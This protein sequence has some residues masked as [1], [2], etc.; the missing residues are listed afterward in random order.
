[1]FLSYIDNKY[2]YC[3]VALN[4]VE[5]DLGHF[6]LRIGCFR[7]KFSLSVFQLS[8]RVHSSWAVTTSAP[9][10][11][12]VKYLSIKMLKFGFIWSW[13][14]RTLCPCVSL[15]SRAG[16]A[17]VFLTALALVYTAEKD[18]NHEAVYSLSSFSL[19]LTLQ[20]LLVSSHNTTYT[21]T[22]VSQML[23]RSRSSLTFEFEY[24][25]CYNPYNCES[26]AINL[27]HTAW[28]SSLPPTHSHSN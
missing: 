6:A 15:L 12:Y 25:L 8:R 24:L 1:M 7:L 18:L 2:T 26:Y 22:G 27:Q 17:W 9:C 13:T 3:K 16:G 23:E 19:L 11:Q 28:S 5:W 21:V 10:R 14:L 4:T 20:R